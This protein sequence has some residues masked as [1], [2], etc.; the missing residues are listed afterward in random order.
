MH[1][2][3]NCPVNNEDQELTASCQRRNDPEF[4]YS[5]LNDIPV[6]SLVTNRTYANIYC[7]RCHSDIQQLANW[8]I[9][10]HCNDKIDKFS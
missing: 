1:M 6:L 9:S 10:I 2:I 4:S 5:H 7:A 3:G 8:N